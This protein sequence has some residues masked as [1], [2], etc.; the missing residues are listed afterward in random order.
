MHRLS[1]WMEFLENGLDGVPHV[2][3]TRIAVSIGIANHL[4]VGA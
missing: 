2:I 4:R 3:A 1:Y